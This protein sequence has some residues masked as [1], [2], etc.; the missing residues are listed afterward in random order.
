MSTNYQHLLSPLKIGGKVLKNRMAAANFKKHFIQ[1]PETYPTENVITHFINKAR[2]GAAI[3]TF[4]GI[5]FDSKRPVGDHYMPP[6]GVDDLKQQ[7]YI[8]QVADGIHLYGSLCLAPLMLELPMFGPG[9]SMGPGG[10]PDFYDVSDGVL[11]M[12]IMG[13][14]ISEMFGQHYSKPFTREM[15]QHSIGVA[16]G[17]ALILKELGI[18]GVIVGNT[19][20]L[21][22]LTNKRTDE[23][24]GSLENR[25]RYILSVCRS[26][27]DACGGD[28]I[29]ETDITVPEP[30]EGG[31]TLEDSVEACRML[32]GYADIVSVVGDEIDPRHVTQFESVRPYLEAAAAVKAALKDR[33][34]PVIIQTLGGYHD[35][36]VNEEI[37]ARGK[38]DIISMAR[39]FI[40]DPEYGKKIYEGRIDDIVPCLRCNKCHRTSRKDP[41]IDACSVN[42]V[43]SYEHKIGRLFDTPGER[44]KVCVVGGGPAG[45]KAAILL[46]E[47]GHEVTLYEK[48]D[49]LGGLLN[50]AVGVSFKWPLK[51]YM[52]YLIRQ[53]HKHGVKVVL[54]TAPAPEELK[55]Q[56][57]DYVIAAL[58][59]EPLM[60]PIPGIEFP[61]VISAVDAYRNM[62]KIGK[63]AVVIGG[64]EIGI[65]TGMHLA[66]H[67]HQVTVLEM[68]GELASDATPTHYRSLFIRAWEKLS[69]SL[70]LLTNATVTAIT[71]EGVV[72]TGKDNNKQLVPADTV[73]VSTGLKSKTEEALRYVDSGARY[74]M[75]GDCKEVANVLRLNQ[76]ALGITGLI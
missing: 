6:Y 41:W 44:K 70:S 34:N 32:E 46:S 27:K 3:V 5:E 39:A 22:P 61:H 68:T 35:P 37:I 11:S 4:P 21:S 51:D 23:Y 47:R 73:I 33:K 45:M 15:I 40:A 13:D 19:R 62:D 24:G 64:G 52:D 59:S 17:Q 71:P 8:C 31:W 54:N 66:E 29:V 67:G 72:Y 57:F 28:F 63:R 18:D 26:I 69:D 20:F 25:M 50:S 65:E 48:T 43:W 30:Q 74:Y 76:A 2:N 16:A 14:P 9:A 55:A 60:P 7:H 53:T 12:Y 1:G 49:R 10:K 36:D 38:A 56:N 58:G 42:P 75:L